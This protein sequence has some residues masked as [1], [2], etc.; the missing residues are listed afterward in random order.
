MAM[1]ECGA[2]NPYQ[3]ILL[4][5]FG[6]PEKMADVMPFLKNVTRGRNIPP[7]RLEKVARNYAHFE[8]KSPL[9]EQNRA[10]ALALTRE[11]RQNGI[12]LPVYLGNRNWP[13]YFVEVLEEMKNKGITNVLAFVTSSFG[14][15]S[16]C[17]QY[18]ENIKSAQEKMGEGA[19][20]VD[21]IRGFYNHPGFIQAAA[22]RVREVQ[23]KLLPEEKNSAVLLFT[24]HSLPQ[25]MAK[26]CNYEQQYQDAGKWIAQ[27]LSHPDW[28]ICYQSR[29]GSPHVPWLEPD[30]KAQLKRLSQKGVQNL[31]LAPIGFLSD[32]IEILYDLDIEAK[33][34]A[35]NL[36]INFH[37]TQTV[38]THPQFVQMIRNLIEER[39]TQDPQRL[40]VGENGPRP[41][42]CP[43]DCCLPG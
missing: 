19:P 25:S 8:G 31:I 27:E 34:E 1:F 12:D 41:D 38:G 4:V 17:R 20:H 9:N 21:Y 10:L 32:N 43:E 18:R 6:G 33:K 36:G 24:A 28:S 13:P 15:Y 14:S 2:F 29:S 30:I 42:I 7:E 11:L 26:N 23:N 22:E 3:A 37:R 39:L 16:S 35:K 5:A 40:C